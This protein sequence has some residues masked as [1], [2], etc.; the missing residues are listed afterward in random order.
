MPFELIPE[1]EM[2]SR[3]KKATEKKSDIIITK[4]PIDT[5]K[6]GTEKISIEKAKGNIPIISGEQ[7]EKTVE[8]KIEEKKVGE[9]ATP[10]M[11]PPVNLN[12]IV[13]RI[14][15]PDATYS[16]K[17]N[18]T[19][20]K[21]IL[22]NYELTWVRGM[23]KTYV[24]K[25]GVKILTGMYVSADQNKKVFCIYEGT[26][27]PMTAIVK[28]IGTGGNF[29]IGLGEFAHRIGCIV[30]DK[31]EM[32]VNNVLLILQEKGEIYVEKK[33]EAKEIEDYQKIF[34]EKVQK[35]IEEYLNKYLDDYKESFDRR[36]ISIKTASFFKRKEIEENVRWSLEHGFL[37]EKEKEMEK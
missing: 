15:F 36:G 1:E 32:Y 14:Y 20:F 34:E 17:E 10:K 4:K 33:L 23:M 11:T 5:E 24:S 37:K 30:E 16:K 21:K 13:K 28:I 2:A 8:E 7:V 19:E 31:D 22:A 35:Y 3:S 27:K 25:E 29:L 6:V 9:V 26:D 12:V 18:Q